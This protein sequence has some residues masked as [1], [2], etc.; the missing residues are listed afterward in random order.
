MGSIKLRIHPLFIA[1]G[2]YYAFT[3]EILLFLIYTIVALLHELGHSFV[4]DRQGYALNRLTLM[5]YGAI[6]SGKIDGLKPIDEILIALAGPITNIIIAVFFIAGWWIYP[7][8]YAYTDTVAIANLSL[9]II[10]LLPFFPLDGG[11][12]LLALLSTKISVGRAERICKGISVVFGV[13]LAI[14]FFITCFNKP[15]FSLLFFAGFVIFGA[16][17]KKKKNAYVKLYTGVNVDALKRGMPYRKQAISEDVTVKKL[18]SVLDGT[19]VNEV[20]VFSGDKQR[21]ILS[22]ADIINIIQNC[23]IYDKIKDVIDKT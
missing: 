9:A 11:R 15:N 18:L 20:V 10:N 1:F 3:G 22:Q 5:P 23:S 21:K 16:L 19:A 2:V 7:L 4:A 12:I 13:F 17:S 6:I 14:L 8:S